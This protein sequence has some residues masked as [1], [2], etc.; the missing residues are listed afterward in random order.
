M[1]RVLH[2]AAFALASLLAVSACAS[3]SF[4][5]ANEPVEKTSGASASNGLLDAVEAEEKLGTYVFYSQSFIDKENEKATYRGSIYGAIKAFYVSACELRLDIALQDYFSGTVG[6]N[7]TAR[8]LDSTL[9]SVRFTLTREIANALTLSEARPIQLSENTNPTCSEKPSCNFTW[10]V[11]HAKRP[12][13]RESR[14][15]N[16]LVDFS[17][18]TDHFQAPLSSA[19]TGKQLIRKIQ[20]LADTQ[21]H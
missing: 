16:G 14:M 7:E 17:G 15:T 12:V 8:L 1:P 21:C 2:P 5:Q 3:R 19:E 13:I 10:L 11:V 18:W 9:Y 20:A 6:K 4:C